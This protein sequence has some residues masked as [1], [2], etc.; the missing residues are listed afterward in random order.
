MNL[1]ESCRKSLLL[2]ERFA[3]VPLLLTVI[4]GAWG[5]AV[6]HRIRLSPPSVSA[7]PRQAT[8]AELVREVNAWS[9]GISTLTATVEFKPTTGSVYT[10]VINE[11]QTV[12]GFI[13]MEKPAMIRILGQAPVVK[14]EIFDMVSDGR[15]FWVSIPPKNKFIVGDVN[16]RGSPKQPLENLRPSHIL[17]ALV[18]PAVDETK[19]KFFNEEVHAST[20][21][22]YYVLNIVEPNKSGELGLNRKVWFDRSNLNISG[23]QLYGPGGALIEGVEYNDYQNF[24]GIRYPTQITL[25]RPEEGYTLSITVEKATFNQ[26]IPADKFV[27]KKPPNST[28]VEL[29]ESK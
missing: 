6:K 17:D 8:V 23:L 9:G 14:T 1:C 26:P 11:Y 12:G 13:L 2:T 4:L 5:C 15:Q 18:I 21:Q 16:Y 27:L 3:A 20:G 28:V 29:G 24:Q 19:E 7:P 25:N 10:G 22:Y